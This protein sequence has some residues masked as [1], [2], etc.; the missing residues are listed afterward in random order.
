MNLISKLLSSLLFLFLFCSCAKVSYLWDQGIG[1]VSLFSKGRKNRLVLEDKSV[2]EEIKGKIRLIEEYKK[3][4]YK[5]WERDSTRI[6]TETTLLDR[7]AVTYLVIASAFNE[8][9]PKKECFPFMGCFPYLGFFSKKDAKEHANFLE[10][11]NWVTYVRPVYAYSTLGYFEDNILSS[12]FQYNDQDLAEMIFHELFH[13]IFFIKGEVDFNEALATYFSREMILDY[14]NFSLAKRLE[15]AENA[16]KSKL[17]SKKIVELT[18]NLNELYKKENFKNKK[19]AEL[20]LQD[21]LATRFYPEV[22]KSC[23]KLGIKHCYAK[24]RKWNNASLAAFLTYEERGVSLEK[25]R[26][27]L[28][29]SLIDFYKYIES[30]YS[31]YEKNRVNGSF[32]DQ[33]FKP[34]L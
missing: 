6:Y 15:K 10:T 32:S 11:Q 1:Q 4:F 30:E 34:I 17:L 3:Y 2:S 12:F 14:F 20:F 23:K 16:E 31:K 27:H 13:T 22:T 21:F 8:I 5:Y 18:K 7:E 33:L 9:K 25:L 29:L 24:T 26:K 19:D 28:S